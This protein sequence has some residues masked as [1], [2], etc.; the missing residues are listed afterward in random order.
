MTTPR[1]FIALSFQGR[2]IDI[3]LSRWYEYGMAKVTIRPNPSLTNERVL[4]LF[5]ARFG[6]TYEVYPTKLLGADFVIKKS[7]YTGV[8]VKLVRKSDAW[9]FRFGAFAPS[10]AVR[11]LLYGLIMY[12]FVRKGWKQLTEEVRAYIESEPAFK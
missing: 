5:Q 7:A 10:V 9:H 4:E 6:N 12:F 2:G 3:A 8:S 11:I 1:D